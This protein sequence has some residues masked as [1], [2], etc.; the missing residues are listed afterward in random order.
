MRFGARVTK[1]TTLREISL[2]SA[3][4][5]TSPPFEFN[6]VFGMES[7]LGRQLPME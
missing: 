7:S 3:V 2:E 6:L 4:N 5:R 1:E